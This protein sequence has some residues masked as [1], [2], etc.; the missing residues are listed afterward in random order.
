[1]PMPARRPDPAPLELKDAHVVALGTAA[2]LLALVGLLVATLAGVHVR[3][4]WWAMAVCGVGLGLLGLRHLARREQ[5][6]R[7]LA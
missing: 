6:R 4:W 5:R 7:T 3:G 2:W 1:M